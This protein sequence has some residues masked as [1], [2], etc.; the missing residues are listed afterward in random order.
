MFAVVGALALLGAC[1]DDGETPARDALGD[2]EAPDVSMPDVE[3]P[4]VEAPEVEV[5]DVEVPDVE[6]PDIGDDAG[7]SGGD[8]GGGDVVDDAAVGAADDEGLSTEEWI[9][10][11]VLAVG[12]FALILGATSA[13]ARHSDKKQAARASLNDRLGQI[14]GGSR[15]LV[16]QGSVETLRTTDPAQLRSSWEATRRQTIELEGQIATLTSNVGDADLDQ[17]LRYL[18]QRIA[19]LRGALDSLVSLRVADDAADQQTLIAGAERTVQELRQQASAAIGPV[20]AAQ[21]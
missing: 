6:A 11:I 13:S 16:D 14:I 1:S 21:R 20:A 2:I 18:G 3:A 5:P 12:A 17:A 4:E 7:G 19:Q 15:W 8:A 9:L 10:L